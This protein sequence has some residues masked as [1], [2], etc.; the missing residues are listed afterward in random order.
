M[1]ERWINNAAGKY[2][3]EQSS[4]VQSTK[5]KSIASKFRVPNLKMSK[6]YAR[7]R[8]LTRRWAGN[9]LLAIRGMLDRAW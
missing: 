8:F 9:L 7:F 3:K 1:V 2:T 4:R 6:V 5:L